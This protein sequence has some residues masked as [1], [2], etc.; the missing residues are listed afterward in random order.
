MHVP[1]INFEKAKNTISDQLCIIR[2]I[3]S[4]VAHFSTRFYPNQIKGQKSDPKLANAP[5][6]HKVSTGDPRTVL[7][8]FKVILF[9]QRNFTLVRRVAKPFKLQPEMRHHR[10]GLILS[11][12]VNIIVSGE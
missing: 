9:K 8:H 1:A 6:Y 4:V 11:P 2:V 12:L 5:D 7:N 3:H 10:A